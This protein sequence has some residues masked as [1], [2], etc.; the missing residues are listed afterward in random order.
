MMILRLCEG[1]PTSM[2]SV[3]AYAHYTY[4]QLAPPELQVTPKK[5]S[6]KKGGGANPCVCELLNSR[7]TLTL[8]YPKFVGLKQPS[9]PCFAFATVT[10]CC[11]SP[12]LSRLFLFIYVLL[13]V[14]FAAPFPCALSQAQAH[15]HAKALSLSL[16]RSLFLSFSLFQSV[17]GAP[18]LSALGRAHFAHNNDSDDERFSLSL[19]S[20]FATFSS[21]SSFFCFS[22]SSVSARYTCTPRSR[23]VLFRFVS[24]RLAS[25]SALLFALGFCSRPAKNFAIF[26]FSQRKYGARS[27]CESKRAHQ[28]KENTQR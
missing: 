16:S 26:S 11:H 14:F 23:Q 17:I 20:S 8:P 19:C 7:R 21:S 15:A 6:L 2:R 18:S 12:S 13:S 28:A 4:A 27:G 24:L 3:A 25:F 10:A 1:E 9:E 5:E 22:S